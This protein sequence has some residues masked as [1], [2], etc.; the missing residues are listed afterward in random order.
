MLARNVYQLYEVGVNLVEGPAISAGRTGDKF[1]SEWFVFP[2]MKGG[3][4]FNV[5]GIIPA[6]CGKRAKKNQYQKKVFSHQ[7]QI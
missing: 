6:K 5:N 1:E 3:V 2:D 4:T 7:L